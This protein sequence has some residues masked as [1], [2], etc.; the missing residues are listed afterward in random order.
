VGTTVLLFVPLLLAG[1]GIERMLDSVHTAQKLVTKQ[2]S[3]IAERQDKT[4]SSVARL[5]EEVSRAQEELRLT[6]EQLSEVVLDRIAE[7]RDRDT[8]LI[9][10]VADTPSRDGLMRALWRAQ[11]LGWIS[12]TGCRVSLFDRDVYLRFYVEGDA[13]HDEPGLCSLIVEPDDGSALGSFEWRPSESAADLAIWVAETL[14]SARL[15]PGDE[16]FKAGDIFKTLQELLLTARKLATDEKSVERELS[17]IIQIC[18]PQWAITDYGVE[19][20]D[21]E[22]TYAIEADRLDESD[23]LPHMTAK[24]WVDYPSFSRALRIGRLL[25]HAD[26]LREKPPLEPPF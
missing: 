5:A 25:Y 2:Q 10:E 3:E 22:W 19:S 23:W 1:R 18:P 9:N 26:R 12:A 17:P 20:I 16:E 21:P 8:A 11:Q 4:D 13:E 14:Q 6:R 7:R 24:V 15:Y